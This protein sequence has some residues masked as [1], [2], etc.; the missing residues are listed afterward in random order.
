[1]ASFIENAHQENTSVLSYND[2]NSLSCVLSIAYIYAKNDYIIHRELASGK[3]F[4]DLVFI[5]RKN[6]DKP[7]MVVELKYNKNTDA[8]ID[9]IKRKDYSHIVFEYTGEVILVGINYDKDGPEGKQH[10]CII[11]R[12]SK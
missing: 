6:V 10:T 7:A 4:A 8:A 5:P 2:E 1:M 12:V 9:Q 3:G 11:E